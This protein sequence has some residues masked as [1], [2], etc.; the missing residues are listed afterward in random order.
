MRVAL[1]SPVIA[2]AVAVVLVV[3]PMLLSRA[4]REIGDSLAPALATSRVA[5][6]FTLGLALPCVAGGAIL[7][8]V[9]NGAATLG[10]QVCVAPV[11]A[12]VLVGAT[13]GLALAVVACVALPV[14]VVLLLPLALDGPGGAP[15]AVVLATALVAGVLLG[16]GLAE[17]ARGAWRGS[18]ASIGALSVFAAV[19]FGIGATGEDPLAAVAASLA[20][21]GPGG[22][23]L[24]FTL[25]VALASGTCWVVLAARRPP[26]RAR[27]RVR[28][29]A[30]GAPPFAAAVFAGGLVLGRR[31]DLRSAVTAA[32]VVGWAGLALGMLVGLEPAPGT[33]LA[34]GTAMLAAAPVPLAVGGLLASG[35]HVWSLVPL[36]IPTVAGAWALSAVAIV[37]LSATATIL[38]AVLQAPTTLQVLPPATAIAMATCV[39]GLM[40]GAAV[41]WVEAGVGDQALSVATFVLTYAS[42][43]AVASVAGPLL[44][45]SGLPAPAAAAALLG[46][47]SLAALALLGR[48]VMVAA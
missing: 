35:E 8:L 6:A 30:I 25:V 44:V 31:R 38:P 42:L 19:G 33:A 5:E 20:G 21:I 15:G 2:V 18:R 3:T 9:L 37:F 41:A 28:S 7:A 27:T 1:D 34:L 22:R 23:P 13:D 40:A 16:G 24:A 48:R 39:A 11:R 17:A 45:R 26:P 12:V 46:A 36:R 29:R 47:A 10:A 14:G 4:A 32:I 43:S